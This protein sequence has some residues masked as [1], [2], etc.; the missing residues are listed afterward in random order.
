MLNFAYLPESAKWV[1]PLKTRLR[2]S[3]SPRLTKNLADS[4]HR[5]LWSKRAGSLITTLDIG[6]RIVARIN[7][8][9]TALGKELEQ[10]S[11]EVDECLTFDSVYQ[12]REKDLLNDL[13]I[14]VDA[15][16]FEFESA[17]EKL[18]CFLKQFC[19]EILETELDPEKL[20]KEISSWGVD[21]GWEEDLKTLRDLFIHETTPW[22]AVEIRSKSPFR[23]EVLLVHD[24]GSVP[25]ERLK[26]ILK[27]FR[28]SLWACRK[29]LDEEIHEQEL[30]E[31]IEKTMSQ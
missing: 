13:L 14:E 12:V 4:H 15:F 3:S 25:I 22:P 8:T 5:D 26:A 1:L 10:N 20:R 30:R 28:A 2:G 24:E 27:G 21:L 16:L 31:S 19:T 6:E 9:L 11:E 23:G 7:A 17:K 29:H 18:V